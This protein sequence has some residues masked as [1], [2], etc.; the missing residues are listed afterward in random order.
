[1]VHGGQDRAILHEILVI[2][3]LKAERSLCLATG[4]TLNV[5]PHGQSVS[6]DHGMAARN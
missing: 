4:V 5:Q 1:M 2:V 6:S 3:Q